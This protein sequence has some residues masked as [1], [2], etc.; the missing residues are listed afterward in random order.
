MKRASETPA[1]IDS[2]N[3]EQSRPYFQPY[4]RAAGNLRA[5][6]TLRNEI[7]PADKR[8]QQSYG[9]KLWRFNDRRWLNSN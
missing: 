4:L 2:L 9:V 3:R 5:T 1:I 7:S 6:H 8:R